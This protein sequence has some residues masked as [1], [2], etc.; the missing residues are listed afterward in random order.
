MKN[1]PC[2]EPI[3]MS[4]SLPNGDSICC[5]WI[6]RDYT[7]QIVESELF[8]N[9]IP[10]NLESYDVILAMDWRSNNKAIIECYPE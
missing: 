10:F 5:K 4:I 6:L 7:I 8:A 2:V 3:N 1:K 9:V